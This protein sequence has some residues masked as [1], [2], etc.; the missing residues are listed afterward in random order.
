[1]FF[2]IFHCGFKP[3]GCQVKYLEIYFVTIATL[4][5]NST[6]DKLMIL[7]LFFPENRSI[8]HETICFKCQI[9]FP[10]KSKK[11]HRSECCLL[12]ILPRLQ[13]ANL[14]ITQNTRNFVLRVTII[15]KS[16]W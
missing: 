3:L 1:M 10:G 11:R 13:S 14:T 16:Y 15:G 5:A 12:K 4:L 2:I 8:F 7:F 6:E 9:L